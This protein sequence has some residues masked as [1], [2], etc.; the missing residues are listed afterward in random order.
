M[1]RKQIFKQT[2]VCLIPLFISISTLNSFYLTFPIHKSLTCDTANI[3][4]PHVPIVKP[5]HIHCDARY[6]NACPCRCRIKFGWQRLSEVILHHFS[7]IY[8]RE[9]KFFSKS[10][11]IIGK[12]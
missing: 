10:S 3:G 6:C 8:L 2:T 4:H 9:E 5:R 11:S 7:P 12:F 1:N